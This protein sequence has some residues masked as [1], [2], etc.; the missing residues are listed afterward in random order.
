MNSY[1]DMYYIIIGVNVAIED[2]GPRRWFE[3]GKAGIDA[4]RILGYLQPF[5][6]SSLFICT[7]PTVPNTSPISF[8]P[9]FSPRLQPMVHL[10]SPPPREQVLLILD[11]VQ[12]FSPSGRLSPPNV[13]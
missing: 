11:N 3:N 1:T 12:R 10:L 8:F 2:D 4:M 13:G 6:N 7:I 5:S 9:L